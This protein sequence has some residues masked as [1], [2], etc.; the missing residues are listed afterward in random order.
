T[1]ATAALVKPLGID[2]NRT[3]FRGRLSVEDIKQMVGRS[4]MEGEIERSEH[5]MISRIFDLRDTIVREIMCPLV[6]I[7]SFKLSEVTLEDVRRKALETGYSRFPIFHERSYRMAGY[8][9]IY[10]ILRQ[11]EKGTRVEDF[12][13]E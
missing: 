2:M 5:V 11:P 8:V 12:V 4:E 10:D 9:D 3:P 13:H 1:S 6:D 7:V